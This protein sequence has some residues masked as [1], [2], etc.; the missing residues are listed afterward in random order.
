MAVVVVN[1]HD[2]TPAT[3]SY[4]LVANGVAFSK[5]DS[6]VTVD[7]WT[8]EET[9]HSGGV[10]AWGSLAAHSHLAKKVKCSPF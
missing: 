7:L 9:Q 6:C 4:D 8:G 3:V 2:S 5:Y 10:Q 1:W